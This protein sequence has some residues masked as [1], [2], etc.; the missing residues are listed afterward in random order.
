M[1]IEQVR[2]VRADIPALQRYV[3]FQNG[4]VSVTPGAIAEEHIRL[5]RELLTR[6]PM[7]I[8]YPDEEYPRREQSMAR[9]ARFFAVA[10]AELALMRGVSEGSQTILRGLAWQPGD[11]IITTVEEEAS[12]FLPTLHVRDRL[13]L[14]VVKAPLV[15]D[16]EGQ[17]AAIESCL[18]K[19]TR[20]IA[21]SHVTTDLGYRLPVEQICQLARARGV[22]TFVDMAHSMG[23]YPIDLHAIG[24]D[25]AGILSYKWMY[26]PYAAGVLYVR[27]DRL[28]EVAV[29]YAGGRAEAWV[30][31]ETDSYALKETAGRF[32]YGPWSW[33]LI[34]AWAFA[35][36]YL[37][38]IGREQIWA[39]TV[40]LATR[41]KQGLEAIPN[42]KLYTPMSPHLSAALVSF[43]VDGWDGRALAQALR[44]KWNI[45]IKPL[46]ISAN[47]LRASVPFFLLE[48][49][50]DLLLEAIATL[51]A[52]PQGKRG[53][54]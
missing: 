22:L 5:M 9:L 54:P 32:E 15:D 38:D 18:T 33:P 11:Q 44:E 25:F 2:R 46:Y 34:H 7:H 31:H 13:G 37:T 8:V 42:V 4:G 19:R 41:L 26:A 52:K 12:V 28:D 30:D 29:T 3:W 1:D 10:P 16:L 51:A 14:E 20:L 50:I 40:D 53:T 39:R 36:D 35:V 27:K 6:G 48:E 49:E 43:G 23:L 24:C 45:I 47:G 17:C 21:L